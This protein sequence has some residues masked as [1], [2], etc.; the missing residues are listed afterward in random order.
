[1]DGLLI[2]NK[3]RGFTSFDVVAKLRG[4]LGEKKIGH[5]GTLDP[6]AEGVLPVLVGRATKLAPLLSGEDKVYRTTLLLGVTTDTQDT[7]GHLLERRPVEI[8]EE[9]LRELI[10]SFVGEQDQLPPMV[11]AKKIDGRKL[12]DLARQGK[13]VERKPARIEI[14]GIDIV[15]ID[16]PRVEMRVFCSA[17]TYIRTLCHDI[18]E[19]A[20]CGGVMESLVREVVFGD[21]L[22]RYALK[23]DEVTS[24]VLTGRLHEKMQPLE[25]LLCRYRRFVCDERREKPARNG[26]PLQVGPDEFEKRIYNGSRVLVMDREGNSIG[27]F[28]Y[29]ENKQILRPIVMIGPEE[30]R[31]PARPPRPAVLSLGKFDGVHIGH[32]AILREMLRQAEEEK[33]GT[34]LFSFTNPPES[35]T[36]HKSGDLL[37]TADEKRLLLK[38]F[39]IGKIIEARFTRAMRE[40]P[41]DVFLKD[42]LI[43]R[44]GMKKIVVGPDCCFGKDRVG[45]VDFLRAHAEELGYT[46][47][48]VEK[49]MMDGEIVSSSRIKALVKEGRMEEAARCLGR[50][51]AVRDRV[52]Y[53]RHLGEQLG[54]PTLNLRMPPEKVFP[55]RGVYATVAELSGEHFPGMSNFG[56]KPTVEK[57]APPACEAH[58]FGLH[59]SRHGEL[60]RLQFLRFIRP[61]TAFAD[62]D[63]LRAQLARDKEQITRFF[64]EQSYM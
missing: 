2:I 8:G 44:Y 34:V 21:W 48:V 27:V 56:V 6:E 33:M 45:N 63:E 42:I 22:L 11:S 7:T 1:M 4:I 43:G 24:L 5:L 39:G 23:L 61:E 30:E 16:L 36:G 58:L 35:V 18:G 14:Y 53:G 19:K 52:G 38:E 59:G 51:F 46:V 31:R 64:E 57:D 37:T 17:G 55:P 54:Y 62:V 20:G 25:E 41:A 3:E 10:E 40:T 26:N 32:Q 60:C 50:P 13:E 49:V 29:D 15:K 47:T 9:A 28:R 12:V